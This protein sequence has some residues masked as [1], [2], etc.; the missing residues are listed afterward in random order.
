MQDSDLFLS[1]RHRIMQT[2]CDLYPTKFEPFIKSPF[3]VLEIANTN[4][5]LRETVLCNKKAVPCFRIFVSRLDIFM[6]FVESDWRFKVHSVCFQLNGLTADMIKQFENAQNIYFKSTQISSEFAPPQKIISFPELKHLVFEQ[7]S[8][9]NHPMPQLLDM[10]TKL[11]SFSSFDNNGRMFM[12]LVRSPQKS[13]MENLRILND[14]RRYNFLLF[15]TALPACAFGYFC[16]LKNIDLCHVK[17]PSFQRFLDTITLVETLCL[18]SVTSTEP[19]YIPSYSHIKKLVIHETP[20]FEIHENQPKLKE[21]VLCHVKTLRFIGVFLSLVT[22]KISHCID[23]TQ[24]FASAKERVSIIN[25]NILI[26]EPQFPTM[27]MTL[28]N[29]LN[30]PVNMACYK[31]TVTC[32]LTLRDVSHITNFRF[33]PP[34]V[35]ITINNSII[36]DQET[37]TESIIRSL[38][39]TNMNVYSFN[40]MHKT[41]L[42]LLRKIRIQCPIFW[43][44]FLELTSLN[45]TQTVIPDECYEIETLKRC[46]VVSTKGAIASKAVKEQFN[47][48]AYRRV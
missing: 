1:M 43:N 7:S 37:P 17:L 39:L 31:K 35:I 22:L 33:A 2:F 24:V 42:L 14:D 40:F 41:K 30:A 3:V 18:T 16:N 38:N 28:E 26:H 13:T 29:I 46:K 10:F 48:I 21:L 4:E 44:F 8:I 34:G 36:I 25:T 45:I 23:L 12:D 6:L 47:Q 27:H 32:R 20:V 19:F 5:K 9:G 15:A 11:K